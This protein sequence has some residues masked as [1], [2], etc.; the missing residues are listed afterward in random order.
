MQNLNQLIIY[1]I[2]DSDRKVDVST[3]IR[4]YSLKNWHKRRCVWSVSK[5]EGVKEDL[6]W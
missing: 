6:I 5:K 1:L 3:Y 2:K 4:L